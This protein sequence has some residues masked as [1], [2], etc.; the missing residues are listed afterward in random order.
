MIARDELVRGLHP[1][2]TTSAL[3]VGGLD[4][5]YF[6]GLRQCG[7]CDTPNRCQQPTS[8]RHSFMIGS[9]IFHP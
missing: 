7:A 8:S 5:G 6:E 9:S 4:G 3:G 2:E 1:D